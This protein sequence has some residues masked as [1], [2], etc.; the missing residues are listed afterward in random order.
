MMS[1]HLQ[2]TKN[3]KIRVMHT[4]MYCAFVRATISLLISLLSLIFQG[5]SQSRQGDV[6]FIFN[7]I[8]NMQKTSKINDIGLLDIPLQR[9]FKQLNFSVK[10]NSYS[11]VQCFVQQTKYKHSKIQ[12]E[13]LLKRH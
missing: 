13:L 9:A 1:D 4:H 8:C 3:K 10:S 6:Y 12:V 7:T 11:L 5:I 2:S